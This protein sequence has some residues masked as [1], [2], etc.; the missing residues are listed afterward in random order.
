MLSKFVHGSLSQ[1]SSTY[2][3]IDQ[4]IFQLS[5][6]SEQAFYLEEVL[7]LANNEGANTGEILRIATQISPGNEEST[8]SAFY[9]V[10][11]AIYELAESIDPLVDPVGARENYFHAATYYRGAGFLL[12]GNQS[13]PRLVSLWS[14]QIASF[15][16]AIALLKPVPGERFT[17]KATDS[18]IGP[19]DIPGYFFKAD[20][21]GCKKLPTFVVVN[22]YDGS[23]QESYHS[24][25]AEVLRRGMNCV[26]YEGPGQPSPRRFQ[27]IGFIPDW[28]TATSPVMDFLLTRRDVDTTRI[29]LMGES[30]G[31][32]LAPRAAS[33]DSRFSAVIALDGLVSLQQALM[34]QFPAALT[35]LYN[36]SLVQEFDEVVNSLTTNN[37]LPINIRWIFQQGLYAFDTTSPFEW[38]KRLGEIVLTPVIVAGLG[39][40]PVYVAKGQVGVLNTPRRINDHTDPYRRMTPAQV[41]RPTSPS[42][43]L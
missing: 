33:K 13:D 24:Q 17:V 14:Q 29:V 10:A 34:T 37:S 20:A 22:G 43:C 26:T 7:S 42:I 2:D 19:Y 1:N 31:G 4:P 25:C 18:S 38:F 15:D 21:D 30:F 6:D 39:S 9:P 41:I 3:P 32:T 16:K 23:Q 40:R 12:I 11:Q 35:S 36:N 27:N 5:S 8:Y 28:W